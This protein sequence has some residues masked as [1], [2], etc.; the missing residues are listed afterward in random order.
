MSR[1]IDSYFIKHF[2][3]SFESVAYWRLCLPNSKYGHIITASQLVHSILGLES[4][5][6]REVIPTQKHESGDQC[7]GKEIEPDPPRH[8]PRIIVVWEE[9]EKGRA[10]QRGCE[11]AWKEDQ[12]GPGNDAHIIAVSLCQESNSFHRGVVLVADL[13]NTVRVPR[14]VDV[15]AVVPL[16]DKAVNLRSTWSVCHELFFGLSVRS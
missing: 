1:C 9:V 6:S 11:G 15:E 8:D 7:S 16:P 3:N 2:W 13:G 12:R 4:V 5:S 10:E 14:H